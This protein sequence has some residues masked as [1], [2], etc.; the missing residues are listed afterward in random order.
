MEVPM[1]QATPTY[2][3]FHSLSNEV[4]A[5]LGF[6]GPIAGVAAEIVT[7]EKADLVELA[8]NEY[9]ELAPMLMEL[10]SAKNDAKVLANVIHAAERRLA[11]ALA[12]VV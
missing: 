6:L 2:S 8:D 7:M 9:D 12:K 1:A 4:L 3:R 5:D 10:T 11:I